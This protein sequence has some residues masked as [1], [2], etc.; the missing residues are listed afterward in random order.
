MLSLLF[1]LL[2]VAGDVLKPAH[3][4]F[5]VSSPSKPSEV[6]L[7][8]DKQGRKA[9]QAAGRKQ[10]AKTQPKPQPQQQG[11]AK[12]VSKA[13]ATAKT[14]FDKGD[15]L[16]HRESSDSV[17]STDSA[18]STKSREGSEKTKQDTDNMVDEFPSE[19]PKAASVSSPTEEDLKSSQAP[20][21]DTTTAVLK[22]DPPPPQLSRKEKKRKAKA[23]VSPTAESQKIVGKIVPQPADPTGQVDKEPRAVRFS[24]D[25]AN[26]DDLLGEGEQLVEEEPVPLKASGEVEAS[27]VTGKAGQKEKKG[28]KADSLDD[29]SPD[30]PVLSRS[31]KGSSSKLPSKSKLVLIESSSNTSDPFSK[32]VDKTSY[33]SKKAVTKRAKTFPDIPVKGNTGESDADLE[34]RQ[35]SSEPG[36]DRDQSPSSPTAERAGGLDFF[37]RQ[38][39]E[40]RETIDQLEAELDEEENAA[41]VYVSAEEREEDG[42][43]QDLLEVK[44]VSVPSSL[45]ATSPHELAASVLRLQSKKSDAGPEEPA[46]TTASTQPK[47]RATTREE[48][49][50]TGV[51]V[52]EDEQVV[53]TTSSPTKSSKGHPY[54]AQ[55]LSRP[56]KAAG[57]AAQQGT[58][59]QE[60]TL[61][62]SQATQ[63]SLSSGV[64]P[65]P[66][67]VPTYVATVQEPMQVPFTASTAATPSSIPGRYQYT[68]PANTLG[69]YMP[70]GVMNAGRSS[71]RPSHEVNQESPVKY[72]HFSGSAAAAAA[73]AKLRKVPVSAIHQDPNLHPPGYY[74]TSGGVPVSDQL[75]RVTVEYPTMA[76]SGVYATSQTATGS[77][78]QH[79]ASS[80]AASRKQRPSHLDLPQTLTP[81]QMRALASWEELARAQGYASLQDKLQQQRYLY[82]QRMAQ[83]QAAR[84]QAQP[85]YHS[86]GQTAHQGS[87]TSP[88]SLL[89][90]LTT[91]PMMYTKPPVEKPAPPPPQQHMPTTDLGGEY[92]PISS[93]LATPTAPAPPPI[94]LAPGAASRM[95]AGSVGSRPDLGWQGEKVQLKLLCTLHQKNFIV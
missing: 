87:T 44:P 86:V 32:K 93:K 19:L 43:A 61:T 75:G 79:Y 83:A 8:G 12:T 56:S 73:A 82:S 17:T 34:K 35:P 5:P 15:L 4:S 53:N 74:P 64:T 1:F 36:S 84:F 55:L 76:N 68:K 31:S 30:S 52:E 21:A 88:F 42:N 13:F 85:E 10:Q 66:T 62:F 67:T 20:P 47:K 49:G 65:D 26:N 71:V 69:D 59:T 11:A 28:K 25:Y 80:M 22:K 57:K 24:V 89:N 50:K 7:A 60:V 6:Q 39:L 51:R 14:V 63:P 38:Q 46:P 70:Q 90:T 72:S 95:D 9:K 91:H 77:I 48:K 37:A 16:Q 78:A 29:I 2:S 3:K 41:L 33:V 45:R 40:N 81:Q 54:S 18:S 27:T 58:E 94:N 92:L 23:P